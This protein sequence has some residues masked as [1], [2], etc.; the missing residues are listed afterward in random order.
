MPELDFQLTLLSR[1]L[2][3]VRAADAA[4]VQRIGLDLEHFGK[5]ERQHQADARISSYGFED[6][7]AVVAA[8]RVAT[9]F[10]RL[11][12]LHAGSSGEVEGALAYVGARP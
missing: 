3:M 9:P 2:D 4:G 6:L 10:V 7:R 1:D 11:S 12:S 5:R 8:V